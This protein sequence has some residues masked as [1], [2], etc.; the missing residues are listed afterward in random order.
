MEYNFIFVS[1]YH[2]LGTI[3]IK[4]LSIAIIENSTLNGI[5]NKE[6]LLSPIIEV[7]K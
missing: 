4:M 7:L 5:N 1:T 6:C 2:V 3:A